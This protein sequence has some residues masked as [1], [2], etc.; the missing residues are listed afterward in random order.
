VRN[1]IHIVIKEEGLAPPIP[2]TGNGGN[3]STKPP[4][5][6]RLAFCISWLSELKKLYSPEMQKARRDAPGF[7]CAEEERT[8]RKKRLQW[9]LLARGQLVGKPRRLETQKAWLV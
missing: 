4:R 9:S 8:E 2:E 7:D 5:S 3:A 1:R 6:A